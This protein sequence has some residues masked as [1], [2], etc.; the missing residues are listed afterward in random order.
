M[1]EP[2]I[3]R[4]V[5]SSL[6]KK[7]KK[8]A[9]K[10]GLDMSLLQEAIRILASGKPM[11]PKYRDH[12]LRGRLKHLRE[13]HLQDDWLLFYCIYKGKLILSLH[14]TGTHTDLLE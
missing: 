13:C 9:Q 8:I 1:S 4:I 14:G 2:P 6:F 3:Y 11:P 5:E 10:R 12:P 7:T